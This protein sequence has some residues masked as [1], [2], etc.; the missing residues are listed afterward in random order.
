MHV[1]SISSLKLAFDLRSLISEAERNDAKSARE[2]IATVI[3]ESSALAPTAT[4]SSTTLV[5]SRV[6]S[7]MSS[8]APTTPVP[9]GSVSGKGMGLSTIEETQQQQQQQ[10]HQELGGPSHK[11][12]W[13]ANASAWDTEIGA[14]G[15]AF[16]RHLVLPSSTELLDIRPGD[17]IL[18]LATGNGIF[19]RHLY[20][21]GANVIATDISP[22]LIEIAKGRST[23]EEL[24]GIFY[25]TLDLTCRDEL[26]GLVSMAERHSGFDA[27]VCNMALMDV[28][29]LEPLAE[30]LPRLLKVGVGR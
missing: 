18:E 24:K 25:M 27:I 3:S 12:I 11:E 17:N 30:A 2:S 20:S 14:S 6:P 21:L 9:G 5:P 8:P 23:E 10:Q 15:N 29:T 19:A 4:G 13:D 28:E 16:Y 1:P 7:R 22:R 26:E